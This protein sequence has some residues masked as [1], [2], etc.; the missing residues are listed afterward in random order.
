V[1]RFLGRKVPMVNGRYGKFA[2]EV[3][4]TLKQ[5]PEGVCLKHY[6]NGNSVKMYDKQGSVLRIETT[7]IQ[8]R[9]FKVY[10]GTEENPKALQ[11]RDLR[12]GVVDLHRRAEVSRASNER[13]AAALASA[14]CS[15]PLKDLA[16]PLCRRTREDGRSVRALNPMGAQDA[17][18][19]ETVNRGEFAINGFRNRDVRRHL[20]ATTTTTDAKQQKRQSAAIT[21]KLR[22]LRS[23]GLIKK[24]SRTHRYV[25]T[26]RGRNFITTVLAARCADAQALLKAA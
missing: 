7:I 1:M 3:V 11:W 5:R 20:Y 25:L 12:K 23:H 16:E 18:L 21:R 15:S 8:P 26:N 9:D 14:Q 10:R 22:L 24:V 19:L 17:A 2:G 4:S 6:V 13:Y